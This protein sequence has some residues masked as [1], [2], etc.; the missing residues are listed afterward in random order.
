MNCFTK[1]L[2]RQYTEV[3]KTTIQ[4]LK[5]ICTLGIMYRGD[6]GDLIIRGYSDS[7]WV[8]DHASRNSTLGFIFMLNGGLVDWNSKRQTTVVFSST[9]VKYMMLTFV[10]KNATSVSLL[11]T[12]ISLFNKENLYIEINIQKNSKGEEQIK[13][14]VVQ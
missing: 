10:I 8:E 13:A 5:A 7:D 14:N 1:N 11:L 6:D 12:N 4:Y 2:S 9:E 3:M